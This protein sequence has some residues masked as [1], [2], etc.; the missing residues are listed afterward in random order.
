[1]GGGNVSGAP[2]RS[3]TERQTVNSRPKR[4]LQQVMNLG[5]VFRR[6]RHVRD[7][8]DRFLNDV[9]VRAACSA[10]ERV[11]HGGHAWFQTD[12]SKKKKRK[13]GPSYIQFQ[14][15]MS[16]DVLHEIHPGR[17]RFPVGGDHVLRIRSTADDGRAVQAGQERASIRRRPHVVKSAK[18]LGIGTY[19]RLVRGGR[20]RDERGGIVLGTQARPRQVVSPHVLKKKDR[21]RPLR[22]RTENGEKMQSRTRCSF[23]FRN[24]MASATVNEPCGFVSSVR[25]R[26]A[27]SD[28]ERSR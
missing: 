23:S 3:T 8:R 26:L 4:A 10:S 24:M 27:S 20:Q 5:Q 1:M 6:Q 16:T 18:H 25:M 12:Q 14:R 15:V 11:E 22:N 2:L 9:P 21:F 17:P 7:R 19:R 28:D 13:G